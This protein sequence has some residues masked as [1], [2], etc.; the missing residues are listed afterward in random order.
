MSRKKKVKTAASAATAAIV[1]AGT[2]SAGRAGLAE[3]ALK[4]ARYKDAI[5]QFKELLKL[6]R[7]PAW[8]DGLAAAYAGRAGQLAAKGMVKEALALWRTRSEACNAPLL[9]GPYVGWLMQTGQIEL[10]LQLLPAVDKLPPEARDHARAQ[11][12]PAV[13]VAPDHLLAG[14]PEESQGLRAAARAAIAACAGVDASGL[15]QALQA[16]SFRSP[17]RDLRPLLKALAL[18]AS[19]PPAAAASLAR[20]PENGPFQALARALR[21]CLMPGAEWLAGLG[22]LDEAGR[23]LVLDLK[24]CPQPQRALV[25]DLMA[26]AG[27]TAPTPPELL[28]LLLRHRRV[29][30]GDAARRL[31]LR[32]LPHAPQRLESFRASF[33]PP[34]VA[35]QEQVLA[36]A[37]ELKLRP[38]DAED[39]WLRLIELLGKTP[40]GQRRAALILRRLADEHT[41]HSPDGSLCVHALDWLA[42]SLRYDPADRETHL[43]LLRDARR[44]G[45]LK[46]ARTWLDAALHQFP[47]N[48]LVLLEAVEIAL[49]AGAFKK[50][51]GLARQVL[52]ADPI[53]PRVRTLIGQAHLAHARKLI[54]ARKLPSAQ[55]ELDEAANWLRGS[56]ER[57]VLELL[58][59]FAAEPAGS[60]DALLRQAV[61]DLGGPLVG[62][63]HLL[64]EGK[65]VNAQAAFAPQDLLRRAGVDIAATPG[66]AEVVALAQALHAAAQ[67]EAALPVVLGVLSGMLGRAATSSRFSESDHLLVCEALHRHG[68]SDLTR[69]FAAAALERWPGRPVFI[70]LDAAARFGAAPW[71]MPELE[72]ERLDQVFERARDQGDERTATRLSKL[73]AAAPGPGSADMPPGLQEPGAGGIGALLDQALK[74]G[75]EDQILDLARRELG[76][77]TFDQLRREVN[78]SKKQFAQALAKLLTAAAEFETGAPPRILP[79]QTQ[80]PRRSR[81]SPANEN[82]ADLFDD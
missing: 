8:L 14:L 28:D 71:R 16:I 3:A 75:G 27:K 43:R 69:R 4:A 20:V 54:G 56:G 73:L 66:A 51:A 62:T 81:P 22:Q 9:D 61:A 25:L 29:V 63:Y 46:Q 6:E 41:H 48:A 12:A 15:E 40:A 59:G 30:E 65:R 80:S 78:G 76:K 35:E 18:L 17:Y 52:D 82:Q 68:Q 67:S 53:N 23:Q 2:D 5:E 44:R 77:A 1:S 32:L 79:P 42:Q 55:R 47:G 39:H 10:A 21:V 13:L 11:L 31:G 49:A 74:L 37:A 33:R 38:E 26:R 34:S 57:G 72:W 50:A 19:D 24:G 70:Y 45:D 36:L 7:R 64:L 58:R 60:G